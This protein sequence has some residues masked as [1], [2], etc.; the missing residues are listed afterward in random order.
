MDKVLVGGV[1]LNKTRLLHNF[2]QQN[3]ARTTVKK[4]RRILGSF[5]MC[6]FIGFEIL[7]NNKKGFGGTVDNME[8]VYGH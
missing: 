8:E 4:R 5:A 6:C 7:K 3:D 1:D 2:R